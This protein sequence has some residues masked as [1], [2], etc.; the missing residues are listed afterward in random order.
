MPPIHHRTHRKRVPASIKHSALALFLSLACQ[1][2]ADTTWRVAQ[3]LD[4]APAWSGHPVGFCLLTHGDRQF[5]AYYDAQRR[6]TVASRSLD[7]E[8]WTYSVLPT[9]IGWDSHNYITMT[10]DDDGFI[11]LCGNM[12][13]VPLIYFRTTEPLDSATF[14]R[15]PAMTGKREKKCTYPRFFR[16]PANELI[17]TYRDGSSGNGDQL[18]NVYDHRSKTWRR[19]IDTPL[20]SGEGRM[21]A[22]H[23]GPIL[24]PDELYHMCWVWRDHGGCETNHDLSYARSKDLV[25]WT[26]SSGKPMKLPMTLGTCEV[27]DPVPA[28]GGMIN[29]NARI[30]FDNQRRVVVSYHKFDKEGKTQ[31]YNARLENGKWRIYQV[32][33]WDY[34]WYFQG[35][36]SIDFEVRV[37]N[38]TMKP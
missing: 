26:D 34:R 14:E 28:R 2:S 6:M 24:G 9:N 30:G 16:G 4:L 23:H 15:V 29:G 20:T 27:I 22:Y 33:D 37:G 3:T 13:C 18:Y 11:H 35:G 1:A 31:A 32:T 7:S 38:V 36:G 25:H 5:A 8:T 17:F 19:L 10:V 21:N 12:H